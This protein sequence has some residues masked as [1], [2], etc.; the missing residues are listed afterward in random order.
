MSSYV[1]ITGAASGIVFG[2][3]GMT[4]ATRTAELTKSKP[5]PAGKK[6][7]MQSLRSNVWLYAFVR[8]LILFSISGIVYVLLLHVVQPIILKDI[9]RVGP[10]TVRERTIIV[11]A[12]SITNAVVVTIAVIAGLGIMGVQASALVTAAGVVS[13][14]IGLA[15]QSILKD[16]LNGLMLLS[17]DQ[18][19]IGNRVSMNLGA[20]T[21]VGTIVQLGIRNTTVRTDDGAMMYIPNGVINTVTNYS[22]TPHRVNVVVRISY[23]QNVDNAM[24]RLRQAAVNIKNHRQLKPFLISGPDV[25]GV[26]SLQDT[27]YEISL[28][29]E[30]L[31]GFGMYTERVMRTEVVRVLWTFRIPTQFQNLYNMSY[32]AP[33]GMFA[34]SPNL[35]AGAGEGTGGSVA[36]QEA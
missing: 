7:A 12:I 15:A 11:A 2:H 33:T 13:V 8:F 27:L 36:K 6:S 5:H 3:K 21:A 14:I 22:Q 9:D 17:E 18:Y 29:A 28:R 16:F 30:V 23:L 31:P 24:T 19:N 10:D 35:P 1:D 25:V 34:D 26:T 4:D 20:S 32:D